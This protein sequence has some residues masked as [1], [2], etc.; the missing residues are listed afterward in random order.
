MTDSAGGD[1]Q[2][3]SGGNERFGYH[4]QLSPLLWALL[5]I[6][7]IETGV[8]HLLIA[9]WSGR[10]GI[11][12]FILSATVIVGLAALLFS[13]RRHPIE[14]NA[15]RLRVRVGFL[16]DAAVPI[17]EVA[18]VQS[19]FA[20]ADYMPGSLLKANLLS[21]P[22]TLVL[23]RRDIVLPGPFGRPRRVHAVA[24]ALDEPAAFMAALNR[25]LKDSERAAA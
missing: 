14:L 23:L 16:I 13:F 11:V 5:V 9:H 10:L 22:N 7:L 6:A 17:D 4:R 24:V 20:P 8:V 15:S 18:F 3:N 21:S 19:G 2:P 25:R 1:V 12:L